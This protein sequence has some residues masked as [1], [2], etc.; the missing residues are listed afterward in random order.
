MNFEESGKQDEDLFVLY[1]HN[2]LPDAEQ[3]AA[4]LSDDGDNVLGVVSLVILL[5]A[6]LDNVPVNGSR[7][8][9]IAHLQEEVPVRHLLILQVLDFVVSLNQ[10]IGPLDKVILGSATNDLHVI[11]SDKLPNDGQNELLFFVDEILSTDSRK[12][13]SKLL[14]TNSHNLVAVDSLLKSV[15]GVFVNGLPVNTARRELIEHLKENKACVA[16]TIEVIDIDI[17]D[18]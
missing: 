4:K 3:S 9:A 5:L 13:Q 16:I 7:L 8:D 1:L 2:V 18:V 17:I 12:F 14:D 11:E 6:L 15:V 10:A